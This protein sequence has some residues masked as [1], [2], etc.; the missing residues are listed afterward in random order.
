MGSPMASSGRSGASLSAMLRL[1]AA[2][3][4]AL[5]V[6]PAALAAAPEQRLTEQRAI[7]DPAPGPQGRGLARALPAEA[8]R[9][10]PTSTATTRD[11]TVK[12]WSG[13]AGQIALGKVDDVTGVVTE[14]WT[15]PQ[16]AWKMAR[17]DNGAF[18]GK[19]INTPA[20]WLG[21]LRRLP[22]RASPTSGGR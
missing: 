17:G 8:G 4:C 9:P 12:V 3:V 19:K 5:A 11:W 6:A 1:L 22:A 2:A 16:V 21:L 14:A 15:G 20:V 7:G 10:T 13:D 18:G